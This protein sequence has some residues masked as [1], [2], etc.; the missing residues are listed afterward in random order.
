MLDTLYAKTVIQIQPNTSRLKNNLNR[1]IL[2]IKNMMNSVEQM[3]LTNRQYHIDCDTDFM[4]HA[5]TIASLIQQH[6]GV[7]LPWEDEKALQKLTEN[8]LVAVRNASLK[9]QEL[10]VKLQEIFAP[11]VK[12]HLERMFGKH[13]QYSIRVSAQIKRTW[14]NEML[15]EDNRDNH[16]YSDLAFPT[17]A[18]QDLDNNGFRSSHTTIFYFQMTPNVPNSSNLE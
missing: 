18:H 13:I 9:D 16:F 1:I 14:T 6:S 12:P 11:Y 7:Y 2:K 15:K 8:D 17:R 4:D 10:G 3:F 5:P